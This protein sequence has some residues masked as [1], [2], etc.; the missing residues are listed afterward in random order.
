[1]KLFATAALMAALA[2]TSA[3]AQSTA[4]TTGVGPICLRPFDTPSDLI[5]HTHVVDART[6]LFYL[7]DG[8]ILKNTLATPC[9]GLMF[10]GFAFLTRAD[11]ICSNSQ[12]IRVL[13]TEQVCQLGAF[14]PYTP[15]AHGSL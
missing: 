10:H 14:S 15:P 11:E 13:V 6:I 7:R 8:R 3:Q 5:D 4:S 9:P 2:A 1:M 12:G